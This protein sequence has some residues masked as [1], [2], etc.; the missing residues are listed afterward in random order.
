MLIDSSDDN[1]LDPVASLDVNNRMA[2]LKRYAEI[3]Q[4]LHNVSLKPAGVR[5]Q[6][7]HEL[8]LC[9]LEGHPARHN[10]S[11][12]TGA[13]NDN[14]SAGHSSFHIYI[15][16]RRARRINSR[17]TIAGNIQRSSGTLTAPH[18]KNDRLRLDH[19]QSFLAVHDRHKLCAIFRHLC[20]IN[21]H[22]V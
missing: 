21:D 14:L 11:D 15:A 5:H 12:V 3:I 9:T 7:R 10:Q 2:Q 1:R 20:Q 4:T 6:L 19:I 22:S 18:G 16:L 8:Y 17:R 13:E